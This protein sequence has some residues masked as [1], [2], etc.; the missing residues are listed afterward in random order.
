PDMK[1]RLHCA[2][3]PLVREWVNNSRLDGYSKIVRDI[4]PLDTEKQEILKRI[5]RASIAAF[6]NLPRL[7]GQAA[8]N[9]H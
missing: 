3:H 2:R 6:E 1:N 5:K 7:L 8:R 9:D 4:D